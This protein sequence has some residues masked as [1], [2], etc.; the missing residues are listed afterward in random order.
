MTKARFLA[1]RKKS[2][3]RFEVLLANS[4]DHK[5]KK[6]PG[7]EIAEFSHLFRQVCYDLATVRSRDW[8][9]GL[10]RFLNNLVT[11]GH[12]SFY[13]SPPGRPR[14]VVRFLTEGFPRLV[15]K[16]WPY[17]LVANLLFYLPGFITAYLA[18]TD[19]SMPS[20]VLPAS[21]LAQ[22]DAMYD[23][24]IKGTSAEA[25]M[26]GFYVQ[27][28]VGIAFKCFATGALFGL[29]TIHTLVFNG[30]FL[31]TASGYMIAQ[32]HSSNFFSFVISH[33]S[34]ELTA[35]VISGMA[36]L[37]LGNSLVH[38][39]PFGRLEAI[40][41][42]GRISL[43]LASGAA[44]M[45]IIAALIEGFWSPSAAPKMLKY[46]VGTCLWIVVALYLGFAGR[47]EKTT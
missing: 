42:R 14:E 27:H 4:E 38:P 11:R 9:L 45:L 17:F 47:G 31:G 3:K 23:Q 28:N 46:I 5:M 19:P 1:K 15:R 25:G 29:G 8:G 21:I 36:G 40:R 43:Q 33:G 39:G 20:R 18:A 32:G 22:M 41:I 37:V 13:R 24:D 2:W 6:I 30:L 35:I 12:N 34:F 7:D 16:N 26:A 10:E 44:A